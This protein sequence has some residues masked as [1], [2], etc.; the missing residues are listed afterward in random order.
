METQR[1]VIK[2][3]GGLISNKQQLCTPELEALSQ[4]ASVISRLQASGYA[5]VLVHGAGSFGHIRAKKWRLAE[6]L[7]DVNHFKDIKDDCQSQMEAVERVR[8]DMLR[9]NRIV[10]QALKR[11][12]VATEP[13]PPHL[14]FQG[15]GP[16]FT[17]DISMLIRSSSMPIPVTFGDVVEV[18][19][20]RKFGILSGDDLVVRLAVELPAVKRLVFAVK[21]VDGAY[22]ILI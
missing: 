20:E 1:I 16:E 3:G 14:Y 8:E 4:L 17:G 15:T 19:S 5:I 2:L 7:L 6:G 22:R 9:L 21:G 10:L 11:F 13:F 18:N 12:G